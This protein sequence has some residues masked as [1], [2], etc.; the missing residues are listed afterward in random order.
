MKALVKNELRQTKGM[1]AIWLSLELMLIAFAYFEYLSLEGSLEELTHAAALFP[2]F[3]KIMFGVGDNIAS[4]IGWYSCIYYW[5][6][7][8]AFPY[9]AYLGSSCM[10]KELKQGDIRISVYQTCLPQGY[11]IVES[12]CRHFQY[13][14]LFGVLRRMQLFH[15]HTSVGGI[16]SDRCSFLYNRRYVPDPIHFVCP[17]FCRFGHYP[18]L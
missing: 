11:R 6:G 4:P 8:L 12:H 2:D 9:A 10:T 14:G 3:L 16:G 7:L 5:T 17:V 18:Y 15:V 13:A 1:L